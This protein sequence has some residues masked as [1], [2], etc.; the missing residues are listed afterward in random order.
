MYMEKGAAY[1]N[2]HQRLNRRIL[3]LIN[4]QKRL[5]QLQRHDPKVQS[6]SQ[7][8]H[9]AHGN[10]V[11]ANL[12]QVALDQRHGRQGEEERDEDED[13]VDDAHDEGKTLVQEMARG[14]LA[15]GG[16]LVLE[17]HGGD[18]EAELHGA[19]GEEEEVG[20]D[21]GDEDFVRHFDSFFF[22]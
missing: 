20:D 16:R 21:R 14:I 13:C 18:G 6:H 15:V 11:A 9:G 4:R 22:V 2:L 19:G 12:E 8:E 17:V 5:L 3:I 10:H 7:R 1:R